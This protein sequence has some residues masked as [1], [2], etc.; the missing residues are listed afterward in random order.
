MARRTRSAS[1]N[2]AAPPTAAPAA[3]GP[4]ATEEAAD[5]LGLGDLA[6]KWV[7]PLP[8]KQEGERGRCGASVLPSSRLGCSSVL[9]SCFSLT[10]CSPLNRIHPHHG[11]A[12]GRVRA[13]RT[14]L[15]ALALAGAADAFAPLVPASRAAARLAPQGVLRMSEYPDDY[16]V[17]SPL[18]IGAARRRTRALTPGPLPAAAAPRA[19]CSFLCAP[20]SRTSW[21]SSSV[22]SSERRRRSPWG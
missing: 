8:G 18:G 17:R 20:R 16:E 15:V 5:G 14:L 2:G 10:E 19:C 4:G 3:A 1:V 6:G 13:M 11:A 22:S 9:P 21:R 12:A 7:S